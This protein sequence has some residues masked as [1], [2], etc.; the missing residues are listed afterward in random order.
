M[1]GHLTNESLISL[2]PGDLGG[3]K[4]TQARKHIDGCPICQ[5]RLDAIRNITGPSPALKKKPS[6]SV[7]KNILE[8]YDTYAGEQITE[9]PA[10]IV[11]YPS[12]RLRF[13][14]VMTGVVAACLLLFALFSHLQYENAPIHASKV[15]G[16]VKADKNRLRKGQRLQPGVMLT[17]GENSKFAIFYG[18]IMKLIAGPQTQISITKSYIDR[19]TGK[20]FFEIVIN[21]GTIIAVF[22]KAWELEYTLITPHGKVS[23]SGSKIAMKVDSS[24]TR[25]VVKNGSANLS[26][27][28]GKSVDSEEGSGYSIT[29]K[30]V[31]SALESSDEDTED[32][33][34]MDNVIKDLSDDD[35][36]DTV[37]Q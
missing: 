26:S 10:T 2:L 1:K 7:L 8:Y 3:V 25:V 21:E 12:R 14:A 27:T 34:L 37:V 22:D 30:E 32:T 6:R 17:T 23:S 11:T 31:T 29:N 5:N 19:K 36:D 28:Q 4:T 24:K 33:N 15:S 16:N 9:V 18:K 13:A 20:I 35:D